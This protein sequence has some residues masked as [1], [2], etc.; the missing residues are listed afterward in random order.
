MRLAPLLL[1]R[2]GTRL[3]A[4]ITKAG[5]PKKLEPQNVRVTVETSQTKPVSP[6]LYNSYIYISV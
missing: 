5:E 4:L 6:N 1:H 3:Q 2:Q